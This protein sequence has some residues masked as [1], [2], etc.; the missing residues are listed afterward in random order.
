MGNS[1][2]GD[3]I[4]LETEL[5]LLIKQLLFHP[6][7]VAWHTF[8]HFPCH[9]FGGWACPGPG[10]SSSPPWCSVGLKGHPLVTLPIPLL[11]PAPTL[12]AQL[13]PGPHRPAGL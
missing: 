10:S 9:A 13:H 11:P 7:V 12:M 3:T 1:T 8:G 2:G 4:A 6:V 5:P